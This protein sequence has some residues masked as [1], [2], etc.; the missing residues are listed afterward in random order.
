MKNY[1]TKFILAIFFLFLVISLKAQPY[2]FK[3]DEL[4]KLKNATL[5][6]IMDADNDTKN[7][8]NEKYMDVFK[9]VW[10]YCP[11]EIIKSSEVFD[12][13]GPDAFFM[14]IFTTIY[15]NKYEHTPA[16]KFFQV[17]EL[18]I[19]T[20]T[21]AY[22]KKIDKK[23]FHLEEINLAENS[24][25]VA[26]IKLKAD[27]SRKFYPME[28]S[29]GDFMGY[30]YLLYTG[31]GMLKNYLQFLQK[32]L[33][34]K[35]F[36][37]E[38]EKIYNYNEIDKLKKSTLYMPELLMIDYKKDSESKDKNKIN[39]IYDPKE[40][41]KDYPGKYELISTTDLNNRIMESDET[42]YYASIYLTWDFATYLTM[43]IT[44]SNTGEI[45]F[46]ESVISSK[47]FPP[48]IIKILSK[49]MNK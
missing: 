25:S 3:N 32:S 43:T 36:Y 47:S 31:P 1:L 15:E 13:L 9:E 21:P 37:Q 7:E 8:L 45:I 10:K 12:H 26:R 41:F 28:L 17:Y 48:K 33:Q 23:R 4:P 20:I 29:K 40:I 14:N 24:T 2:L 19:W 44:N 5:Y 16:W 46:K 42:L 27:D 34:Q 6:V 49:A 22:L 11:Y 39:T 35:L 38:R 30:P 18:T